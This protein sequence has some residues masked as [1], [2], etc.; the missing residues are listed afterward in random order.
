MYRVLVGRTVLALVALAAMA[1]GATGGRAATL[2]L[3]R[4]IGT[5]GSTVAGIQPDPGALKKLTSSDGLPRGYQPI[6]QQPLPEPPAT[7]GRM[8][9][10]KGSFR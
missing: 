7:S 5:V 6:M 10:S 3:S 1:A 4:A 8:R 2:A 9:R